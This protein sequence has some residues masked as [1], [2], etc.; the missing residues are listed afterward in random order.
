MKAWIDTNQGGLK[1]DFE[2]YFKGLAH[3]ELQ[4]GINWIEFL[5]FSYYYF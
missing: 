1:D 5:N 2:K 4:V 3:E